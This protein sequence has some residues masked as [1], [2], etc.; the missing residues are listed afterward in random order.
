MPITFQQTIEPPWSEVNPLRVGKIPAGSG[1]PD[2]FVCV[3]APDGTRRRVDIYADRAEETFCFQE[4]VF[5]QQWLAIGFGHRLYLLSGEQDPP[6][7]FPLDSYFGHLYP[8]GSFL[9]VATASQLHCFNPDGT[10]KWSS[11]DLGLDGVIIHEIGPDTIRGEGEWDPPG[12]WKA[13]QIR[14]ATGELL[15]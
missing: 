10:C 6:I 11:P 8:T 4:A 1:T 12:G 13:F 9:L 15:K 3:E 2:V 7:I 5:W 14:C